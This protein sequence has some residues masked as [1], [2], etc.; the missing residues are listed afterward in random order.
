VSE[1]VAYDVRQGKRPSSRIDPLNIRLDAGP[2]FET[3]D[4]SWTLDESAARRDKDGK[5]VKLKGEGKPSEANHG[6]VTPSLR[7]EKKQPH[8]GGITFSY[9]EQS[10]VI[11]LPALRR[12]KFP[13]AS[14]SADEAARAVLAA[15]G[16]CA[17]ALSIEKGMDLRSRCLLV[18]EGVAAWEIVWADGR[19]EAFSL[20][21]EAACKLLK[22]SVAE[23]RVA[24]LQWST[25]VV[26]LTPSPQLAAL[27]RKSREKA[28]KASAEDRV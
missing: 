7:N 21:A 24:G 17:A 14:G 19:S 11:S 9:A 6:N 23:A 4:G 15:L 2:L 10:V 25:E 28:M 18:P 12:L 16:L 8:H 20:S 5:P 27:V 3:G 1:V 26:A 22:E 13:T